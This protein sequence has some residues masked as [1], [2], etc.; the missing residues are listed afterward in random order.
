MSAL[1]FR[2]MLTD[3]EK[4]VVL[5]IFA[6]NKITINSHIHNMIESRNNTRY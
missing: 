2:K 1:S 4:G 5:V 3:F 6:Y